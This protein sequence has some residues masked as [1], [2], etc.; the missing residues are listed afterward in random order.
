MT[1]NLCTVLMQK[2]A[3]ATEQKSGKTREEE[4]GKKHRLIYSLQMKLHVCMYV[5]MYVGFLVN[6]A[7]LYNC[8]TLAGQSPGCSSIGHCYREGAS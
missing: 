5:C 7:T 3:G 8:L 2:K 1:A 4:G 6:E